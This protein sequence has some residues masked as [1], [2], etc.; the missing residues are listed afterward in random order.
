MNE[1]LI[2]APHC[3]DE[4]L[5]CYSILNDINI[6][7]LIIYT[8]PADEFRQKEAMKIKEHFSI[9]G[10]MFCQNI[11]TTFINKNNTFYFPCHDEI[12]PAHRKQA[13]IGE[14][15]ARQGYNVIFYTTNM[16]VQWIREVLNPASKKI[17]LDEI[18]YSQM[19]LWKY[20]HKYF[21]FEGFCKWLF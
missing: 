16:N 5:G 7:P 8:E 21:I 14:T 6:K 10:Q 15:L 17:A 18:Y 3:D 19:E 1:T 2:I 12:H 4:I 11:P 13:A 20:E 9:R